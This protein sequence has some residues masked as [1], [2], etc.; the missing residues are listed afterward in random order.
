MVPGRPGPG[1]GPRTRFVP[2]SGT[3]PGPPPRPSRP[4][5]PRHPP[6]GPSRPVP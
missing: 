5:P 3:W 1:K 4:A 6:W 2:W